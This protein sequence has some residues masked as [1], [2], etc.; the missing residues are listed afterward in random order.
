MRRASCSARACRSS[1]RAVPIANALASP[2]AASP[3]SLRRRGGT[4]DSS[5]RNAMADTILVV[6]AGSSSV[7]FSSYEIVAGTSLELAAKGQI[8]GVG[9]QPRLR[10][11]DAHGAP[12]ID[13]KYSTDVIADMSAAMTAVGDW[14]RT[15]LSGGVPVAVGHRVAHGG[16]EF[17]APVKVDDGRPAALTRPV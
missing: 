15:Y 10:V 13:Q 5:P 8:D 14:L 6:N 16:P 7:K 3:R 11:R 9:T 17:A 4:R 1:S 12:L 2:P